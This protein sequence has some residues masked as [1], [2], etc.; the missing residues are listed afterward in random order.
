MTSATPLFSVI[1]PVFNKWDLT[2]QCLQSL[3]QKTLD[4]AYEVIVVDNGSSDATTTNL[5]PLGQTLFGAN[6]T[7]IHLP[8]NLNFG[9]A[10]NLGAAKAKSPY[11]FFL[12]ND[13]LLTTGWANPLLEH[14]NSNPKLAA[15]GPILLYQNQTVQHA[16]IVF[17]TIKPVHI[18][19]N[20]PVNHPL[21]AKER[22][23]QAL[24][25]AALMVRRALFLELGGFYEEYQNGFEDVD[26]CLRMVNRGYKLLLTPKATIFHLESQTEGRHA[27]I[28]ANGRLLKKRCGKMYRVDLHIQ[29]LRDGLT[30]VIDDTGD[31]SLR[32]TPAEEQRLINSAQNQPSSYW[33]DLLANNPLWISG[34]Q[35]IADLAAKNGDHG[36]ALIMTAEMANITGSKAIY[37]KLL[38][39]EDEFG[40]A[41]PHL[42]AETHKMLAR[43]EGTRNVNFLTSKL[44]LAINLNDKFLISLYENKIK[45][46]NKELPGK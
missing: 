3:K 15:I 12:N 25:A 1:I 19:R 45:A 11:L 21:L 6:F 20:F 37:Q 4:L 43:I 16:G 26:L 46:L 24:T 29:A 23:F 40:Q 36:L 34:R 32:L 2:E 35:Y 30:A 44:R 27:S 31:L 14:L 28:D 42:F 7:A 9:P 8:E 39:F 38:S 41:E 18:Y 33:Q 10:C 22:S 17:T 5:D 13:T